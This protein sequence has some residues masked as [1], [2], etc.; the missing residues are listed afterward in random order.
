[1][2][3]TFSIIKERY[4]DMAK[5]LESNKH[6]KT[7]LPDP[8]KNLGKKRLVWP[9]LFTIVVLLGVAGI[10]LASLPRGF[11]QDFSLIGK[12]GNIVVLVHDLH[13]VAS[14]NNMDHVSGTLRKEYDGRVT[15]LVADPGAP[16][17]KAF[18]DTYGIEDKTTGVVFFA[19]D[20]KLIGIAYGEQELTLFRTRINQAFHF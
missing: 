9:T 2:L 1:M 15:F 13:S 10:F 12:G 14:A 19:P 6:Q 17:G 4:I 5:E 20:G 7:E 3:S 8:E 16:Q 18:V 11:S